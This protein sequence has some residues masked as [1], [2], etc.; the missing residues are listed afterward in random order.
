[1]PTRWVSFGVPTHVIE[2]VCLFTP[3]RV[4]CGAGLGTFHVDEV[5]HFPSQRIPFIVFAIFALSQMAAS[6]LFAGG[7]VAGILTRSMIDRLR[8]GTLG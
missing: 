8:G 2:D 4:S 7:G 3:I 5:F 6:T 1:M